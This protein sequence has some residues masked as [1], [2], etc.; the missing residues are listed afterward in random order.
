VPFSHG[1]TCQCWLKEGGTLC[2]AAV[3]SWLEVEGGASHRWAE[4]ELDKG[5]L[6][7]RK[8]TTRLAARL[9]KRKEMIWDVGRVRQ[10]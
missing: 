4:N 5:Q 3:T 1:K 7:G 8:E 10:N 9:V 2:L 6:L